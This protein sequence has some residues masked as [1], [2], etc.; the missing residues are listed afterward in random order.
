M[1]AD[2]AVFCACLYDLGGSASRN[3]RTPENSCFDWTVLSLFYAV[4]Q[5]GQVSALSAAD[6][7]GTEHPIL[8]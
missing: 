8:G 7:D 3:L 6:D 2:V 1:A 4:G 5:A